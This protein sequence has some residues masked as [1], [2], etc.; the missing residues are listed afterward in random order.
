MA[1]IETKNLRNVVIDENGNFIVAPEHETIQL[2][3]EDTVGYK[4]FTTLCVD[5]NDELLIGVVGEEMKWDFDVTYNGDK[6]HV[7]DTNDSRDYLKG[8]IYRIVHDDFGVLKNHYL[9]MLEDRLDKDPAY[10]TNNYYINN[11]GLVSYTG[12]TSSVAE[13]WDGNGFGDNEKFN[14]LT[15]GT[16]T[17]LN[18]NTVRTYSGFKRTGYYI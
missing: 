2:T 18:G 6:Y 16:I 7:V 12:S 3:N 4:V 8:N 1:N 10:W 17:D 14:K 13:F 11:N 9:Y 5:E 15:N